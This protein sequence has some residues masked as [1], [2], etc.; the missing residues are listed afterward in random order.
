MPS[1][2]SNGSPTTELRSRRDAGFGLLELMI[3]VAIVGVL[4]A[5]ALPAYQSHAVRA[6]ISEG[7]AAASAAK[8]AVAATYAH[9]GILPDSN[10]A[11]GLAKPSV[12]NSKFVRQVEVTSGGAIHAT[13]SVS[14]VDGEDLILE[15]TVWID[16]FPMRLVELA[17]RDRPGRVRHRCYEVSVHGRRRYPSRCPGGDPRR[18]RRRHRVG[19]E[20]ALQIEAACRV[21]QIHDFTSELP[22]GY[23]TWVGET[24]VRL[25][26]GQARRI[27]EATQGALLRDAA[28]AVA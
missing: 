25:S 14:P 8:T 10:P 20:H 23:G 28:G 16:G 22:D 17:M 12:L 9:S 13:M 11:A 1:L 5:V 21:A 26:G 18:G 24:G 2:T 4:S 15:P 3:V 7:I 27:P 6:K 19:Q